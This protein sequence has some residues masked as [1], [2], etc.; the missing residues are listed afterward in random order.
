MSKEN[1][2][3]RVKE[4]IHDVVSLPK[5]VAMDFRLSY[6]GM[7]SLDVVEIVQNLEEEFGVKI[8]DADAPKWKTLG[9]VCELILD[10]L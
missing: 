8:E 9:D 5:D 6:L 7:D 1:V 4:V 3:E 2:Q 10:I